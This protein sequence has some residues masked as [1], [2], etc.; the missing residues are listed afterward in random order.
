[1]FSEVGLQRTKLRPETPFLSVIQTR[2]EH[3][4]TSTQSFEHTRDAMLKTWTGD[5]QRKTRKA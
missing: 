1:M 5:K 3:P 2:L 4:T